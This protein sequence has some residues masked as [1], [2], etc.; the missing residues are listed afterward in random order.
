MSIKININIA[1]ILNLSDGKT[2]F[3]FKLNSQP[4]D[5]L[6]H[7]PWWAN[8]AL[9]ILYEAWLRTRRENT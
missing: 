1:V 2:S 7:E 4:T 8:M 6:Q 9:G 3:I 5:L